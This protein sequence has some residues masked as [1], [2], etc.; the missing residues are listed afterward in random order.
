MLH[1]FLGVFC[2]SY[3]ISFDYLFI[4]LLSLDVLSLVPYAKKKSAH[5]V[6]MF[7]EYSSSPMHVTR[8]PDLKV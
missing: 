6:N 2:Q 8:K 7:F 1:N 4:L 3:R 5:M